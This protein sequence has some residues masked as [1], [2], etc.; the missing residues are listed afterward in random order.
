MNEVQLFD[1]YHAG[2]L[3][4]PGHI[5]FILRARIVHW[6]QK[7]AI[8]TAMGNL[9]QYVREQNRKMKR[10]PGFYFSCSDP[11]ADHRE[12]DTCLALLATAQGKGVTYFLARHKVALGHLGV[13]SISL[14]IDNEMPLREGRQL[15][16]CDLSDDD[17]HPSLLFELETTIPDGS[18]S[19]D[20]AY[21]YRGPS[22][23]AYGSWDA[24]SYF[25]G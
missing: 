7:K 1:Q 11:T 24:T 14:F 21:Y 19:D 20:R 2:T 16:A 13:K 23:P 10:W 9:R 15:V 12:R 3:A 17:C 25:S 22:Q 18:V 8:W 6:T 4:R 5:R